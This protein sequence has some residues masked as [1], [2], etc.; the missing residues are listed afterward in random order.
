[1]KRRRLLSIISVLLLSGCLGED[2]QS[3]TD[4]STTARTDTQN[5]TAPG[6]QS[7]IT[8]KPTYAHEALPE[9]N[10]SWERTSVEGFPYSIYGG[11][12]GTKATYENE[13][14]EE[15]HVVVLVLKPD[16]SPV[17]DA[18]S[19]ACAGWP[20]A[21]FDADTRLMIAAGTGTDPVK[22]FTPEAPPTLSSKPIPGSEQRTE[23]LLLESPY[24]DR[25]L[26]R[27]SSGSC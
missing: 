15:H 14:S 19:F 9:E 20:V 11:E 12:D 26:L 24:V 21:V 23:D 2:G 10:D 13:S 8:E 7:R 5:D 22:T 6:T 4:G 27:E 16:Y 3:A 17:E 18:Q 25:E 1:M